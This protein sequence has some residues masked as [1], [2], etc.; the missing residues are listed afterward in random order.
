MIRGFFS[1]LAHSMFGQMTVLTLLATGIFVYV[2]A[3]APLL[4]YRK[5][6]PDTLQ[7]TE[8]LLRNEAH[9][10]MFMHRKDPEHAPKYFTDLPYIK[11]LMAL[12]P[13]FYYHIQ[14][15]SF[16]ETN[17]DK[18]PS[19]KL[20]FDSYVS[21]LKK[22]KVNKEMC[23]DWR[24]RPAKPDA[25]EQPISQFT[26]C[27]TQY[28]IYEFS[29]L[30]TAVPSEQSLML[31][32]RDYIWNSSRYALMM[33]LGLFL[34]AAVIIGLNFY[35]L[36]RVARVA[37]SI[38]TRRL[39]HPLPEDHLPYEAVPLVRAINQ[40]IE[41]I[42][43]AKQKQDF[44]LSTAAHEMRTPL[45][46]LRTR[47]ELL[48]D[49]QMKALLVGDIGRLTSLVNQ[50]LKLMRTGE[51]Q[52]LIHQ[53]NLVQCCKEVIS[54]RAPL[55]I[56]K[57]LH[58]SFDNQVG[59]MIIPGDQDLLE[60]AL[61]NLL[62][63]AMSFSQHG[64]HILITIG[65]DR[66]LCIEDS[67]PGIHPELLQTLF[68]PFAKFPPNRNGHGL[69]LAIVKSVMQLHQAHISVANKP[70]GGARFTIDFNH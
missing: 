54:D 1:Q 43:L 61:A 22:T 26:Y 69:G 25:L 38:D 11:R 58:I 60:V 56:D 59:D 55:A 10:F 3:V 33:A 63:N 29:G 2:V 9:Q 28:E 65:A 67:G 41:K 6:N 16:G 35:S 53:V 34:I 4:D 7:T 31:L 36:Q 57:G 39:E 32:L 17:F 40:M 20:L 37:A 14:T 21:N 5:N 46:V 51:P 45:A 15:E 19:D 68:N 44:F 30:T 42:K 62:D 49:A 12:N 18:T 24:S 64:D 50:L 13:E 52:Q 27:G 23:I 66:T 8:M 70:E 48:D 47:V